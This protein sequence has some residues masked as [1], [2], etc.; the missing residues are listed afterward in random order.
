MKKVLGI[1]VYKLRNIFVF[2]V[3]V[4]YLLKEVVV[5][6]SD[7]LCDVPSLYAHNDM[8][9]KMMPL[10]RTSKNVFLCLLKNMN[11]NNMVYLSQPEIA[12][13]AGLSKPCV[14]TGLKTLSRENFIHCVNACKHFINPHWIFIDDSIRYSDCGELEDSLIQQ[15]LIEMW[16]N[17]MSASEQLLESN[18]AA[19]NNFFSI[20]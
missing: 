20:F 12:K 14:S 3:N 19:F 13:D 15:R 11:R 1:T 7:S 9:K 17:R 18:I 6:N 5:D 4:G 16:D 2:F 8:W 10:R